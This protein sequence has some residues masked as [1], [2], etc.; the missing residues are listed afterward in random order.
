MDFTVFYAK[1]DLIYKVIGTNKR[2][3]M[4]VYNEAYRLGLMPNIQQVRRIGPDIAGKVEEKIKVI[5]FFYIKI[6]R[7]Q[8]GVVAS[9]S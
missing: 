3:D 1:G 8:R 9:E 5:K 2:G 4:Q 7:N 6:F